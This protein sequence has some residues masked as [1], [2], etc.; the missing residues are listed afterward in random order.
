MCSI[1]KIS[2]IIENELFVKK[3]TITNVRGKWQTL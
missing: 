3:I 2:T 1:V